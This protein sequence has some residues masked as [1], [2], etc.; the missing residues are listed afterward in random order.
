MNDCVVETGVMMMISGSE[1]GGPR[2]GVWVWEGSICI[3]SWSSWFF[4]FFFCCVVNSSSSSWIAR[5]LIVVVGLFM[6]RHHELWLVELFYYHGSYSS[7][8]CARVLCCS[9]AGFVIVVMLLCS[10]HWDLLML[11]ALLYMCSCWGWYL[12]RQE[13]LLHR[14]CIKAKSTCCEVAGYPSCNFVLL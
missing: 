1:L 4:P 2:T 12:W 5:M 13:Q 11:C 3:Y 10:Y 8:F 14:H 9:I 6:H 7:I